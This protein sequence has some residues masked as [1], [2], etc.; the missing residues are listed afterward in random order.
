MIN[1]V[2]TNY[3]GRHKLMR[4]K[5]ITNVAIYDYWDRNKLLMQQQITEIMK[6]NYLGSDK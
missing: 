2:V 3:Q 5:Q 1:E 4:L 6:N